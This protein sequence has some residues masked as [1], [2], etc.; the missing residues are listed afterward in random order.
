M[1]MRLDPHLFYLG[2]ITS[3]NSYFRYSCCHELNFC[4]T[5]F[6]LGLPSFR[7]VSFILTIAIILLARNGRSLWRVLT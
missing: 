4:L 1:T 2:L 7:F 3:Q 6:C 5:V